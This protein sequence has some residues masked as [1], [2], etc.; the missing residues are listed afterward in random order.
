MRILI[1]I[2][3]I[4]ALLL[5]G[6][7]LVAAPGTRFGL[8]EYTKAF[9]I[10]RLVASPKD[11]AGPVSLS[12]VF[13]AAALA[14]FFGLGGFFTRNAGPGL[15][16]IIAALIA[17]GAGMIP[18][19]MREAARANPFIHDITTD[20]ENPPQ[21]VAGAP[22]ERKNPPEYVGAENVRDSETTVAEAQRE[23]FPDIGPRAVSA[24]VD[25]TAAHVL[26]VLDDMHMKVIADSK[27]TQGRVIEATFTSQWFG[28]IDD[29]VVR[30]T[31]AGGETRVDVRSKSRVGGSDLGANAARVREFF[32]R[33]DEATAATA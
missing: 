23:A 26:G 18:V 27:T 25:E 15:L 12:P 32:Q 22:F 5:G 19:K 3:I 16:A 4:A 24:G 10:Y 6:A 29:F 11:L 8:W 9:E 1:W 14:L 30:L 2:F 31:S 33:L 7:I 20:F 21:I 13:T 28:F 17:G